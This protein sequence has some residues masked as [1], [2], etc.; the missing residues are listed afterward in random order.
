MHFHLPSTTQQPGD[1]RRIRICTAVALQ[2]THPAPSDAMR[3]R[4]SILWCNGFGPSDESWAEAHQ[5]VVVAINNWRKCQASVFRT[6]LNLLADLLPAYIECSQEIIDKAWLDAALYTLGRPALRD[7][8][9]E[10]LRR[11]DVEL[12]SEVAPAPRLRRTLFRQGARWPRASRNVSG[13]ITSL[14]FSYDS[15]ED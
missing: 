6:E 7:R 2:Q 1:S 5:R 14:N 3:R 8:E 13:P 15:D 12:A 10:A 4:F 11:L 9:Y